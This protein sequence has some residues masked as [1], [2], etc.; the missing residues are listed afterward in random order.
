MAPFYQEVKLKCLNIELEVLRLLPTFQDVINAFLKSYAPGSQVSKKCSSMFLVFPSLDKNV[1]FLIIIYSFSHPFIHPLIAE[2]LI[3]S[4]LNRTR[5]FTKYEYMFCGKLASCKN[6][7]KH[8]T[9][10]TCLEFT[11]QMSPHRLS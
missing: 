3:E 9:K 8:P 10:E 11:E 7:S 6:H 2:I 4:M 1:F 5:H